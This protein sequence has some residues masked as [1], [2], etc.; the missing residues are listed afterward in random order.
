MPISREDA[1]KAI[2]AEKK[3]PKWDN[4]GATQSGKPRRPR[5]ILGRSDIQDWIRVGKPLS[6]IL[7]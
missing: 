3:N 7:D 6:F 4:L 5:G 1:T 2:K